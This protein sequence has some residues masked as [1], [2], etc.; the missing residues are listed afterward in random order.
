M[1]RCSFCIFWYHEQCVG[2]AKEELIGVWLCLSC[3]KVPQ[4]LKSSPTALTSYIEQVKVST[5]SIL[6]A[7]GH[8]TTQVS[9]SINGI[10]DKLTAL[11]SQVRCKYKKMSETLDSLY[12]PSDSMETHFDQ[13][14]CQF[15]NKT[16]TII[17]KIKQHS[18]NANSV[19]KQMDDKKISESDNTATD[20]SNSA[21]TARYNPLKQTK[22][23][24]PES[25]TDRKSQTSR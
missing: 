2:V 16:T 22:K 14:T 8:L 21:N 4:G 9:T 7:L 12:M 6:V 24:E 1:L 11:S 3:R 13:K 18:E 17:D 25:E 10:N 5:S 20:A 15:L 23:F 19:T